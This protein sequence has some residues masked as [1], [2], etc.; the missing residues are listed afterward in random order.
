MLLLMRNAR[1][2][3]LW[4]AT[5]FDEAGLMI[6]FT[7]HGWLALVV[8]DS[9]FWVGAT[10]GVNGVALMM[11]SLIGGVLVDRVDR[12]KLVIISHIV[13]ATL[14]FIIAA[15]VLSDNIELWHV[16][17]TAFIRGLTA[18]IKIPAKRALVMD[19]VGRKDLLRATATMGAA[20]TSAGIFMPPIA[21]LIGEA[22]DIGWAY[23]IMGVVGL[24][25]AISLLGLR[26]LE[27]S[28]LPPASPIQDL[29]QGLRYV[30]T[31]PMIRTLII[32]GFMF[33][34]FGWGHE[35]MLPVVVRDVLHAGPAG[36]GYLF[37]AGSA[38]ALVSTLV[39]SGMRD[40]RNKPRLMIVG[41]I[42]FGVFLVLFSAS[43]WFVVSLVLI[44]VAYAF[45]VM[46]EIALETMILTSVRNDMRGRVLSIQTFSFGVTG[47]AGFQTGAI[48]TLVGAP[49]AIAIGG[50]VL[51]VS[52]L[53]MVKGAFH[54]FQ[55]QLEPT[56]GD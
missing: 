35:V 12:R 28:K 4:I 50:G 36:L 32:L 24:V 20:M 17:L 53:R 5:L 41:Y 52:G 13:Q 51:I 14:A 25:A 7:M 9:P 21:G 19:V 44:A 43:S 6:Y 30:F 42:G 37:S 8:T 10:A 3:L 2:R 34:V 45:A 38:G 22:F 1:F 49:V 23:V 55:E 48:A 31:T 29:K 11:A 47:A 54:R 33:D 40:I 18:A 39:I 15:L 46:S 16:L 27:T 56:A 26:G